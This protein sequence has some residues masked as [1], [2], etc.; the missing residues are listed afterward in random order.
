MVT[1][2]QVWDEARNLSGQQGEVVYLENGNILI[3]YTDPSTSPAE[4]YA[5]INDSYGNQV[6]PPFLISTEPQGT[7]SNP[8]IIYDIEALP[9][10]GFAVVSSNRIFSDA[11]LNFEVYSANGTLDQ[12]T[13]LNPDPI[14]GSSRDYLFSSDANITLRDDGSIFVTTTASTVAS[15]GGNDFVVGWNGNVN[16]T[17]T[18][19][20]IVDDNNSIGFNPNAEDPMLIDTITIDSG[21][22][23]SLIYENDAF[24]PSSRPTLNVVITDETGTVVSEL[25]LTAASGAT[26]GN[27]GIGPNTASIV[28]IGLGDMV[29]LYRTLPSLGGDGNWYVARFD[30]V[31]FNGTPLTDTDLLDLSLIHI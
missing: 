25:D 13:V 29:V 16:G 7:G 2:P 3:Y 26:F 11:S 1:T 20:F 9:G 30:G 19:S 27:G 18:P 24:G 4:T 14:F 12:A 28:Y 21:Q 6:T 8:Q 10:G 17:F 15:I 23:A 22:S 5:T 31:N